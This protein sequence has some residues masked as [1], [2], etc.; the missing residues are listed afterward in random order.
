MDRTP[1][2]SAAAALAIVGC[3]VAACGS[4][5]SAALMPTA[6][7]PAPASAPIEGAITIT[8]I[9]SDTAHRPIAGAIVRVANG[10]YEGVTATT[11]A[12]GQYWLTGTFDGTTEFHA[13]R[14]GYIDGTA[15]L[16]APCARCNPQHWVYFQLALPGAPADIAGD[17]TL[18]VIADGSCS[19]LPPEMRSRTYPAKIAA[20][21]TQP[22]P[23]AT[24][25]HATIGGPSIVTGPGWSEVWIA[26]AGDYLNLT[27]G[28]LH[29]Q[30]GLIDH[31][32]SNAYF[33]VGGEART[34]VQAGRVS[35][36]SSD[37]DG[38][39]EYCVL[40]PGISPLDGRGRYECA[41]PH[42]D[43]R[44]VCQ[45]RNHRLLFTRQ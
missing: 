37:F 42:S 31:V 36:I 18:T 29:G 5:S 30:P 32:Y 28:D 16:S 19:M 15:T 33:S 25:F 23:A 45:S 11:N 44:A 6:A 34:T 38:A 39:L 41:A 8:G 7:T 13:A 14:D 35:T 22:T 24:N 17:Y 3:L 10:A 43:T 26:V 12:Q 4:E 1:T 20:A 27:L 2:R 9:V 40:T 21:A